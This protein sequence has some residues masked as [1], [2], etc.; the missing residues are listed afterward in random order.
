M[1]STLQ[2]INIT[3]GGLTCSPQLLLQCTVSLLGQVAAAI[4]SRMHKGARFHTAQGVHCTG[5]TVRYLLMG[6]TSQLRVTFSPGL[7]HAPVGSG[8]N[9]AAM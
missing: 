1:F 7:S 3:V 6:A 8:L 2:C 4:R 9:V 5:G